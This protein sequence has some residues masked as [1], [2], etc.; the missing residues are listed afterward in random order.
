MMQKQNVEKAL[1]FIVQAY[2]QAPND[3]SINDSL[4][5][6]LYNLGYYAMAVPYLEKA[7]EYYP[8]SAIISSHLGDAYWSAKRY[9]EAKFQWMHSLKLKDELGE[10]NVKETKAKIE[11]GLSDMPVLDFDQ[12]K[13]DNILKKIK[14][15]SIARKI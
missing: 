13:V 2:N 3:P 7:V 6:A 1:D 4:G 5:Y 15:K 8:S 10:L 14:K 12:E 9:N 11:N